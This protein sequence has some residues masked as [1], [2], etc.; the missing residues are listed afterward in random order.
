MIV[1][2]DHTGTMN[3]KAFY[4]KDIQEVMNGI[5]QAYSACSI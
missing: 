3:S 4:L 1:K 2:M 5:K